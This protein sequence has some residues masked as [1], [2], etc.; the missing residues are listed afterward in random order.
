MLEY[1]LEHVAVKSKY[2]YKVLKI[3]VLKFDMKFVYI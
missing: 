3:G 1:L 2:V